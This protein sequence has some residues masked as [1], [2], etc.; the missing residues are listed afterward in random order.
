MNSVFGDKN[1]VIHYIQQMLNETYNSD[2][3]V[4]GEYYRTFDMN[5][6][7]AHYIAK[8]LERTFPI[9]DETTK[10]A[11]EN[12]SQE[13]EPRDIKEP[14]SILNYFLCNNRGSY[15]RYNDMLSPGIHR[16]KG[17][18]NSIYNDFM[19]V[20]Q[21]PDTYP[22]LNY[23]PLYN[24]KYMIMNDLPLFTSYENGVYD[25]NRKTLFSLRWTEDKDIKEICELDDLITSYLLGRTITPN[26]SMEDIYYVQKLLITDRDL[27]REEKGN[28]NFVRPDGTTL[29]DT[30]MDFQRN[31]PN[32][33]GK[34]PI[35][36]TG[37]FDIFTEQQAK[38]NSIS[39]GGISVHG[40]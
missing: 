6:G 40:L 37:Y 16:G 15:L 8:Y 38:M 39:G 32:S 23:K 18:Y 4:T 29:T 5:Y 13:N 1:L 24:G 33:Y 10:Q 2:I 17:L 21:D 30:I 7:F 28:W 19:M 26:S 35:L 3:H 36:V 11:Y 22:I 34:T 27:Y 12:I 14:I 9:L 31:C 20:H 25:V